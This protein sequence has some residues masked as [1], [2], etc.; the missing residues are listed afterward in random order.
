MRASGAFLGR[1]T[2]LTGS[3]TGFVFSIGAL[4]L[5]AALVTSRTGLGVLDRLSSTGFFS[6]RVAVR[7][8]ARV[9]REGARAVGAALGV[10]S[11]FA[12]GFASGFT[13]GSG[14][15]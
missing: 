10:G 14:S 6:A 1:T 2:F 11:G 3:V 9:A 5:G 4:G 12:T 7:V 13:S 8:G 15:G